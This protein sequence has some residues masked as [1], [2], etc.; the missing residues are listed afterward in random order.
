MTRCKACG[1]RI[2]WMRT[3]AGRSM[4]CDRELVW[5]WADPQGDARVINHGGDVVRCFLRGARDEATGL[6]RVPH[7]ASCTKPEAMRSK[8]R[9][10]VRA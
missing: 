1:A 3:A 10:A 2:E 6:G 9:K 7:W 4:P 8:R 5:Y